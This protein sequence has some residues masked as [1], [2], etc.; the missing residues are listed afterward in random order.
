[1][2]RPSRHRLPT[3]DTVRLVLAPALVFIVTGLDRGYQTE[4]WQ[5]LAR[6]RLVAREH[7]IVSADRFTFTVPGRP[8]L[9]NNWLS[10]LAY[11]ALHQ[12]GGP[13]L[14]RLANSLTLAAALALLVHLC[15]RQSHSTRVAA[16]CGVFAF[17][18]L[19]QTLL[20]RPQSF[21]ILLF[22]ALH[23]LLLAAERRPRLLLLVPPIMALWANVH[24]GFAVGL[25]L[26]GAFAAARVCQSLRRF[27]WR[28]AVPWLLCPAAS[29]AATLLNPYG[30]RVY[31]YAGSLS[32]LGVARGIEEWLPPSPSTLVGG[33][34]VASVILTAGLALPNRR[35][36]SLREIFVLA[37]F[38]LPACFAVRMTV[39]WFLAAAPIAARWAAAWARRDASVSLSPVPG[40][41]GR[42]EGPPQSDIS[43]LKSQI[44]NLKSQI[45]EPLTPTLSP[46]YGGEGESSAHSSAAAALAVAILLAVCLASVPGFERYSPLTR[47]VRSTHRTEADLAALASTLPQSSP[48][49]SH[50]FARL[51][52]AN[53]LAWQSDGRLPVFAEGH[54]ELYPPQTWAQYT[55]VND[56]APGWRRV[57]DQ[58]AVRFLLL[59]Q[60]YHARLLSEV[61]TSPEWEP[62][63]RSGDALLFERRA[64]A[65]D[66]ASTDS[67]D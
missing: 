29:L 16:A 52:W 54:V 45:E 38:L 53:Y 44:S 11:Y 42:G 55:T 9:D 34:F 58:H 8:L 49:E 27:N 13:D 50:I 64:A 21:S 26:A 4:L 10:Q 25:L 24:G 17:L 36:I 65:H 56:G 57:L 33:A 31:E 20:V 2:H 32:S 43:N 63:G 5:H 40:G 12:L 22:V 1:M 3:L 62:R 60:T 59:D 47:F 46:G 37:A 41:V 30:W 48:N 67:G 14:I 51:E 6:G 18:G 7:A 19:W 23:A 39:W 35:R 28:A 61:R 15:R 66:L